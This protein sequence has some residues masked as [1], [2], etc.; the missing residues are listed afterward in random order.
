MT[1]IAK[2]LGDC[3]LAC[4]NIEEWFAKVGHQIKSDFWF[5]AFFPILFPVPAI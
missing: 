4:R 2:N 5:L 3:R 1:K